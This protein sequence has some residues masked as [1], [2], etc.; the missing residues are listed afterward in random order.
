MRGAYTARATPTARCGSQRG[1]H[2]S[3]AADKSLD[4]VPT[5]SNAPGTLFAAGV[6]KKCDSSSRQRKV[7]NSRFPNAVCTGFADRTRRRGTPGALLLSNKA[8]WIPG[9]H[10]SC[11]V[12]APTVTLPRR[13]LTEDSPGS[14]K[15]SAA[16]PKRKGVS[17]EFG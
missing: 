6:R 12:D 10:H 9:P 17:I 7:E 2:T 1:C 15:T 3:A 13:R 8:F 11:S 16:S 14:L 5:R 4:L